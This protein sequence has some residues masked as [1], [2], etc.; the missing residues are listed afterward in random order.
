MF[1]IKARRA[2]VVGIL[3]GAVSALGINSGVSF[4]TTHHQESVNCKQT[5]DGRVCDLKWVKNA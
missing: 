5:S 2:L 4:F 3:L 1:R